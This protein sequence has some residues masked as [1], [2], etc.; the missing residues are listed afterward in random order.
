MKSVIENLYNIKLDNLF[1]NGDEYYFYIYNKKYSI[2][3]IND[4]NIINDKLLLSTFL[5]NNNI[6]SDRIIYNKYNSIVSNF[7]DNNFILLERKKSSNGLLDSIIEFNN[8]KL[9]SKNVVLWDKIWQTKLNIISDSFSFH[10]D[11]VLNFCFDFYLY[12]GKLSIIMFLKVGSEGVRH[13]KQSVNHVILDVE[14][15]YNPV[16]YIVDFSIR[17][18]AEF[19]RS[20]L[21]HDSFDKN[22]LLCFI[23]ENKLSKEELWLLLARVVYPKEFIQLLFNKEGK[24]YELLNEYYKKI[25]Y[26][27]YELNTLFGYI[28]GNNLL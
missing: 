13:V 19:Y 6:Y 16:N 2:I 10:N 3:K 20:L 14:N 7:R 22:D 4:I 26:V 28:D 25:K 12:L 18:I 27:Y 17:D 24:E 5:F 15:F 1:I 11:A 8:C 21:Y 9:V 23:K